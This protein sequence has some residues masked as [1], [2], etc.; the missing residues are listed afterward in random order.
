MS[1][2]LQKVLARAG[3]GSRREIELMIQ[4]GRVSVDGVVAKLGDRLEDL[5]VSVRIDGHNI[6][7][8]SSDEEICRILAYNKPEGELCTRHDPEGR[9][10]V[11]DRLPRLNTGR[12]VSV[13]R[14]DANTSGLLLFTTDGEL[15]NR[16]MHPSRT[17]ERE[18]MVRV[19]G[20]VTEQMVKNVVK[21]VE[22]EDGLARFEDVVYAG[23]E[24]MNHTFYV[25][26]TEGRN[27][28]VR[29]LWDSQGVT[30]SRL[31]RVRYGDV[32]LTKDMPRGGWSELELKEVNE[33]RA[34]VELPPETE[35]A[36]TVEGQKRKKGIRQIRRAVRRHEERVETG[37]GRGR[38]GR[39]NDRRNPGSSRNAEVE[40]QSNER[41]GNGRSQPAKGRDNRDSR[42]NGKPQSSGRPQT[43]GKPQSSGKRKPS[44]NA[45]NRRNP[46]ANKPAKP[47]T[48][49]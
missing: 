38:R 9:R 3:Q 17:V 16:L 32:Y 6:E 27:R 18:Y 4:N 30:V 21:G 36:L 40:A 47:R 35:T 26:I 24:G 20:E 1:E 25:V 46:L 29:R 39:G 11:F 10:T 28:E 49:K 48:R 34:T 2:K 23:G 8:I 45:A 19:F 41:R 14:L 44:G 37:G 12:W 15:A 31:K 42:D 43:S 22:L 7:L 33:L 13:G 5:S